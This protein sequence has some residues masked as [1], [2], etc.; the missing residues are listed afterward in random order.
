MKIILFDGVCC[1]CS[2]V[3]LFLIKRDKGAVFRFASLQSETGQALAQQCGSTGGLQTIVYL[4]N[5]ECFRESSA[6]LRILRDLGGGWKCFYPLIFLPA[7]IRDAVYRFVARNRYR[8]FGKMNECLV[9][10]EEIRGRFLSHISPPY[11][12][13][14]EGGGRQDTFK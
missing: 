5:G 12:G 8:L 6:V 9:P 10:T 2:S 11:R 14:A 7:C 3:V 4:R 13:G 1:L